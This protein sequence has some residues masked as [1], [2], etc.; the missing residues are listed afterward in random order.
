MLEIEAKIKVD[1]HESVRGELRAAGARFVTRVLERNHIYDSPSGSLRKAGRALRIRACRVL[2]GE[3]VGSIITFK[4]PVQS[5]AYKTR[6]EVNLPVA[7]SDRARELLGALGFV[8]IARFEKRRE[9]WKLE[10]A[11]IDLDEL[12]HLGT[13]VEIEAPDE[14]TVGRIQ[15][16]LGLRGCEH[17]SKSY[18]TLLDRACREKGISSRAIEFDSSDK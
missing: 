17:V 8:E 2:D 9:V 13:F 11:E 1:G 4:G 10:A 5:G 14:E 7:S 12:P 6:H 18:L 15:D 16:R 3:P